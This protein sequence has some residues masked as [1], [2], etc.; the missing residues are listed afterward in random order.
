MFKPLFKLQV[1]LK[2][3]I[4]FNS[5]IVSFRFT[6]VVDLLYLVKIFLILDRGN[7]LIFS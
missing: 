1:L 2:N 6:G 7:H 3:S 4:D 5:R